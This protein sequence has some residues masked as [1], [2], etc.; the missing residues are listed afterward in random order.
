MM[1]EPDLFIHSGV[2]DKPAAEFLN[3]LFHDAAKECVTDIHLLWQEQKC[4][5][6]FRVSGQLEAIETIDAAMAKHVDEKIRSRSNMSMAERHMPLDGR[7]RLRFPDRNVDVRV[8]M[9]PVVGGQKCVCRLLDQANAARPL[10][11]IELT[12]MVRMLIDELIEE[13]H[14]MLIVTG[15]TGSGKTTTLYGLLG[16]LNNGARNIITIENPVE[17]LIP[18]ISQINIDQHV[19]FAG[20]MRA[21][22]R[23]DPDVIMLGE[24][25]DAETAATAV[26]AANTGHLVLATMHANNSA[27]AVTR[28]IDLG[29]DPQTL[30]AALRGVI[31]QRLV[32]KIS[33]QAEIK[34]QPPSESD[35]AWMATHG[36]TR[37]DTMFAHVNGHQSYEGMVPVIEMIKVDASVRTAILG[38]RGEIEIFNAAARQPQF[39]TLAQAGIRLATTA[40]T[41]IDQVKKVVGQDAIV[42]KVKRLGQILVENDIITPA[43]LNA[44][45]EKQTDLRRKGSLRFLG[46]I[47][48]DEGLCRTD[49]LVEAIGQTEDAERAANFFVTSGKL[50]ASQLKPVV[51]EWRQTRRSESIFKLLVEK[52]LITKE[53]LND[54]SIIYCNSRCGTC[55]SKSCAGLA[56]AAA[57]AAERSVS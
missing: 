51:D 56:L 42:T 52:N 55:R 22:L 53:E 6:Q 48:I 41:S 15:P 49:R 39:E 32:R 18:G 28:L 45:I 9:I 5:V 19:T 10:D 14:G 50:A 2:P 35:E 47:L 17:Y 26:Q 4:S 38:Q 57:R 30:S 37:R 20:A 43:Q 31:A 46:E 27:L 21:S 29:V 1:R 44:A 23:Q 11:T 13:P 8:S 25:R 34:W 16:A 24:I 7:M 36:V 54:S 12:P 40:V 33:K 3:R